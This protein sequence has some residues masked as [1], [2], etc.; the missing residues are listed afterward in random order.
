MQDPWP[1]DL[2]CVEVE[3]P[4]GLEREYGQAVPFPMREC[5]SPNFNSRFSHVD[6]DVNAC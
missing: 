2:P 1:D 4:G 5:Y 6:S 3:Q